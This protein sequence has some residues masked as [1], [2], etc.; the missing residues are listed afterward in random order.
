MRTQLFR[1]L[2]CMALVS[3][4]AHAG[5]YQTAKIIAPEPEA[6]IHDNNGNLTVTVMLSPSLRT[7]D[8]DYFL[9]TMDGTEAARGTEQSIGL[10]NI[11]RGTHTLQIEIRAKDG[12][13]LLTSAP[14]IFHMW[15]ASILFPVPERA[16]QN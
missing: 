10:K 7:N 11:D 3:G 9:L 4:I 8:G 1:L 14:V 12:A 16:N 13:L 5:V 15:R 6:T 2:I